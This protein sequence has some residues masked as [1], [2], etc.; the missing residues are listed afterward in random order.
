MKIQCDVCEKKEAKVYCGADEAALCEEC[1]QRVH[2]AN[3]LANQHQRFSLLHPSFKHAPLCD[4]C[5]E[6]R[7]LMFCKE[8]R[9]ILCR[10]CDIS[11]HK[12][13]K[14]TFNHNR[15]LLTGVTISTSPTPYT[16]SSP[17]STNSSQPNS[18]NNN[19]Y[20]NNTNNNASK[21][22]SSSTS[23]GQM[24]E[25]ESISTTNDMPEY[26]MESLPGWRL[27][28]L[29]DSSYDHNFKNFEYTNNYSYNSNN[30]VEEESMGSYGSRE[31]Y[32]KMWEFHDNQ[33]QPL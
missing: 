17:I 26:L 12:T 11:I 30:K 19:S 1:D 33:Q 23:Y 24:N 15:F 9:A 21:N 13:N 5:Q 22:T 7:A 27:E 20:N 29:I 2:L 8:D 3:K 6:K 16:N 4:I 18:R 28:D 25:H 32:S 31:E 10:E 14:H